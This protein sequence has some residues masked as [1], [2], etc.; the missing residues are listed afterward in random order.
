MAVRSRTGYYR[1]EVNR[2][3]WEVPE[4]YRDLKQVGTG[5]Y[6][7]VCS[8]WDRRMGTQ[9][10]IKK[11][12]RP[13]QSKL[14]AKRAYR[15]LRLLKHMKHENV[16]GLLDVFTA[17]ISLDRLR[18][19]YLVMPFMGTDLGKLMKL[20]RL[21]EDRVQFLVYQM[22]KGLKDLKP[23][24]LAINPD[25]E[26]KILDFGLARQ[27][28]AE[29]TGYVVTRW[30]RAPEVIL[31]WMHYT[32]TA[33]CVLEKMLLLDPERRVSASEALDLPFFSEF[34]DAE[35]ETEALP[36]DQTM[37]NTDLPLDQWKLAQAVSSAMVHR[38]ACLLL[39]TCLADGP[40]SVEIHG[41]N[42]VTVGIPYGF[43]CSASC[44]P[45]CLYTWTRG[46]DTFQGP[47]LSL[48]LQHIM[49]TQVLTCT[50]VNPVT[51]ISVTVD[52]TLRVTGLSD[53]VIA[54]DSRVT[55]GKQ[56]S[57]ICSAT[58]IPSCDFIWKFM[59]RI[60]RGDQIE[61]PIMHQDDKPTFANKLEITFSDYS[62]IEPLTCE[63]INIVSRA[64]ITTTMNL[65]VTDPISVHPTSQILPVSGRSFSLE[66]AGS[67]NPESLTWLK[68]KDP[69]PASERVHLS[70]DNITMTFSPLLQTDDGLYQCEV[71]EG[72][73]LIQSVGY[74][75]QVNYGPSSVQISGVEIVTVGILYSFQCSASC[76]PTCQFIWIWGNET[77]QD[78]DLSLQLE[79]LQ[80]A[81]NLTCIAVNP[82][83]GISITVQKT[84]EI[85]AGPSNISISGEAFLVPGVVSNFTCLANCYPSCNYSWTIELDGEPFSTAQGNTISVTPPSTAITETLICQVQDTVSHLYI[86]KSLVLWVAN[87]PS[88]MQISG[89]DIVSVGILNGFQCSANCYPTCQFTWTWGNV[90]SQGQDLSLQLEELQPAQYLICTAVNPI[91]G[92]S[93]TVQKM[94]EI[95]ADCYPSC[96]YTWTIILDG[97]PFSTAQGNTISV[98]PPS[99]AITETLICQA[100][101]TIS[102]LY[103][104]RTLTLFV[105]TGPSNISISGQALL[106]PGVASNFTCS[107]DCYPSCSYSW[108]VD[109]YGNPFSTAQGN[110]ISV[111]PP[112]TA[113][114]E[115]LVC[116]ATNTISNLYI[117]RTLILRVANGPSSVVISGVDTMTVGILYSFQ[118]SANCYP[119]CQFTWIWGNET[120]QGQDLSLQLEE[121]Q[122][123]Q[124]LTC[125]AVNPAT[126]VTVTV[127]KML[128]ITGLSDAVIT[129]DS[130]VT[131]GKQYS[132][133][134]S[135]TCIP[136]CDFTWKFM[137][138]IYRG[139]QIQLPIMHQG[140]EPLTCEVM[141]TLSNTTITVTMNIT[142]IDPFEVHPS[143]QDLP[144]AGEPF[145]LQCVGQQDT[146]SITWLKNKHP[147]AASERVH[148]SPDNTS[149]NF[150][151]LLREDGGLYQCLVLEGGN[152]TLVLHESGTPIWS[153][154]YLLQVNYGPDKVLIVKPKK[155]PVGE[156][157]FALPASVT[158]L[159]CLTD[160]F[161]VCSISW[162]YH[163]TLLSTN[164]TIFFTPETP[165]NEAALTCVAFNSVT[166][167][168]KTAETTVVVP[169]G[170][171]NVI[172]SGPDS[173]E[174]GIAASFTCAAECT[175]S[176][177]FTWILNGKTITSDDIDITVNRHISKESISCQAENPITGKMVMVNGTLSVSGE[178][179]VGG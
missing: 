155:G 108:A 123:A 20:E 121:L 3:V 37:D 5:A 19:F 43:Q 154:G 70:P 56:Y 135:A 163:G 35:E 26:L 54:G 109:L 89:V 23:G 58:C 62:K 73:T 148:F 67:Q 105:A 66:C 179:A 51:G 114:S 113:M 177:N 77:S 17:E 41:V 83:T 149:V 107:A 173:L 169:D 29:M 146:A 85:A 174:I 97:E 91:T 27:A 84:L 86:S 24:N 59:G 152:S 128:E 34:R 143:S 120:S 18:D 147:M 93:V 7:T 22:L 115:S 119:T 65:T 13:F 144:V 16:I 81:Q 129:G 140:N 50:A 156:E 32:Q 6:G 171:K 103:I 90:T 80:P 49:P 9:V 45:G 162:F 8:A 88:S 158:E 142:I 111:I 99:T 53:A 136:S 104:S 117:S 68:N 4:R 60:Y 101:N 132:Y 161:P 71:A 125:T 76:Y 106:I 133:I 170:P 1:Q 46:N 145:S 14:F 172:I 74:K 69:M 100:K 52:K 38:S 141:N 44:N 75:M 31:N 47:E 28:D 61:L 10:A 64:T 168:N 102:N 72:R 157:M 116:Q 164:A 78:Q 130:R 94:L 48:E 98:I 55:I 110:T 151:P 11:L 40:S 167:K 95:T 92:V 118:C 42:V 25:C 134:C 165:P 36:Y 87:G 122:P 127:Q 150:S 33:V 112:S 126:G 137:G 139:D 21:T 2:T 30:Y 57:Y 96:N 82:A 15:E 63:A 159:Q 39:L 131:I 153:V 12:H 176:C 166:K 160:C 175:P 79:E 124:N 178:V 138:R